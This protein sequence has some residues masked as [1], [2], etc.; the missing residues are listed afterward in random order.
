VPRWNGDVNFMGVV[1]SVRVIP[2]SL[3]AMARRYREQWARMS[4]R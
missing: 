1:G 4:R 2:C 3:E